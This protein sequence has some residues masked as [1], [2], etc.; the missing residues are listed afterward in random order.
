MITSLLRPLAIA[1]AHE[2]RRR[3][4]IPPLTDL[5]ISDDELALRR[6]ELDRAGEKME[7]AFNRAVRP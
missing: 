4:Q 3:Q 6:A 2:Q 1:I 5:P 7:A